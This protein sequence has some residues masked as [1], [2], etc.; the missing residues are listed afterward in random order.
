MRTIHKFKIDFRGT[1][2]IPVSFNSTV[3]LFAAQGDSVFVWIE[4]DPDKPIDHLYR[5]FQVV[6]TGHGVPDG[7]KHVASTTTMPPF[8]WHLYEKTAS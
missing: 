1:S 4:Y 7:W 3:A 8:V 6:G 5:E 2:P